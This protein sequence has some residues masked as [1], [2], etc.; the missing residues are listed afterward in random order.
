MRHHF[1]SGR[2]RAR[3]P[4]RTRPFDHPALRVITPQFGFRSTIR[5]GSGGASLAAEHDGVPLGRIISAPQ[6]S[7]Q[8]GSK[9]RM[10]LCVF[11]RG[12]RVRSQPMTRN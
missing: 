10:R 4:N 9:P 11:T 3:L 7:F 6:C 1:S 12:C 2:S 8:P 5:L